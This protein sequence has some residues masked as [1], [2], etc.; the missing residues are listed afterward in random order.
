MAPSTY[1][2]HAA[3]LRNPERRS[4]RDRRDERLALEIRRVWLAD[5]EV[6][7]ADK[8]WRQ[9]HKVDIPVGETINGLYKAKL[10]HQLKT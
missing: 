5:R 6:Y 8:V 3:R 10:T 7:G 2:R 1:R 4:G 9:L